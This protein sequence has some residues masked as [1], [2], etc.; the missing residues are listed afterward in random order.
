MRFTRLFR[1]LPIFSINFS[2]EFIVIERKRQSNAYPELC[3][4]FQLTKKRKRSTPFVQNTIFCADYEM[5]RHVPR[6]TK[7]GTK[8][9]LCAFLLSFEYE[10]AIKEASWTKITDSCPW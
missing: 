2:L 8:E 9:Q 5:S 10:T 4:Q 1:S 6:A 3:E 7:P